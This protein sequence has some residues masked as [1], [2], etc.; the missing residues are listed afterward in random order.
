VPNLD[1]SPVGF[2]EGVVEVCLEANQGF[3][4]EDVEGLDAGGAEIAA[5]RSYPSYGWILSCHAP[6][7]DSE[8]LP[9]FVVASVF[10]EM[11][12]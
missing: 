10:L 9:P 12:A 5:R 8:I 3:L 11:Q 2:V 4:A 1:R 7:C 6:H